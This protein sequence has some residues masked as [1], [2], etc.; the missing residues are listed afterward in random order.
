MALIKCKECGKEISDTADVCIHCGS[1]IEK[2]I[3]CSECGKEVKST[4]KVCP[5]CGNKLRK[6]FD[7]KNIS[8]SNLFK[9]K[10]IV[11]GAIIVVVIIVIAIV[12]NYF[13]NDSGVVES[14]ISLSNVYNQIGCTDYYCDLAEDGSYL[15]IDS[16]PLDI[17]DYSSTT[18]ITLVKDANE[19]LGFG[20]Q[21][22]KRMGRTRALDGTLTD[23][24]ENVS[25]SWTYHPDNGIEVIYTL[26]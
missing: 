23:E 14:R 10:K 26:K 7:V 11:T 22:Y 5:N 2:T 6:E 9:N 16:N 25:V 17:D 3:I 19:A 4:D 12:A 18:A 8:K 21:L 15:E 24:N 1:P 13:I 20:D